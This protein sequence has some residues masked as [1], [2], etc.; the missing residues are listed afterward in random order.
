MPKMDHTGP[1][2]Q[3]PRTGRNLG[4]CA[5]KDGGT[6]SGKIGE[7]MGKRRKGDGAEGKGIRLRSNL[8]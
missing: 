6:T 7:G 3:G 4:R 2:G 1:E 8:P 5:K